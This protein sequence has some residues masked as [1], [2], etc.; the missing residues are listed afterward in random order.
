MLSAAHGAVRLLKWLAGLVVGIVV[1][2]VLL[3]GG[4]LWRLHQGPLDVTPL[5]QRVLPWVEPSLTV[6]RLTL[7]LADGRVLRLGVAG[8]AWAGEDGQPPD[9]IGSATLGFSL[10][11]LL[12]GGIVPEDI[13]A[14][15]VR[16][17][18]A[19]AG[20]GSGSGSTD[21]ADKLARIQHVSVSDVQVWVVDGP[22][23]QGWRVADGAADFHR[24]REGKLAGQATAT[25]AAGTVSAQVAAQ[26]SYSPDAAELRLTL[27]PLSPAAVAAAVPQLAPLQALDATVALRAQASFGAGL[28][29]KAASVHAEAGAGV[30]HL[31]VDG[32][33]TSPARFDSITLDAEGTPAK[34]RVAGLRLVLP[35]PSGAA[36][37]TLVVSGTGERSDGRFRAELAVDLDH[38][39]FADLPALWPEHVGGNAR[40]WLTENLT[41]GTAH[42]AHVAFTLAGTE[43]G[44][45]LAI[46]DASGTLAAEDVTAWWLRP[47]PPIEHGRVNVA[48]QSPD[49]VLVTVETG[50]QGAL[51]ISDGSVRITGLTGRD[52]V[53]FVATDLAGP[54]GN[55]FTLLRN[56]RLR[57]LSKHPVPI[58]A[59][60]GAVSAHLTVQLPLDSKVSVDQVQI[61]AAGKV[62]NTH[63]GGI[64]AGR[65]IDRGQLAFDVTN[66][67]L[68]VEGPAQLDHL[69]GKLAVDMDFR[70][71]PP[72]QVVQHAA[73]SVRL[74][75]RGADAAG[76]AALGLNAG[77]IQ[78]SVD[79]TE[80]RDGSAT[81][82]AGADLH[83][84]GLKTPLGWSKVAGTP[85]RIE[86]T[87]LLS[88]GKLVGLEGVRAEAPGL[89]VEA[90]SEMVGGVPSVVHIERGEI[91]RTSLTGTIALPQREG[92]AYK[93]TLAGPRLDLEGP[94]QSAGSPASS[95]AKPASSG[96]GTPYAVDLR[97]QQVLFGPGRAL[98]P[99]R[100]TAQGTGRRVAAGRLETG[101]PERVQASLVA[102]GPER[103]LWATAADLG[104]LL[105]QSG[106][107]AALN[108]GRL[109]LDGSF[110]DRVASSPFDGTVDLRD[111]SVKGT[112]AAVGKV[113]QGITVYGLVDA[114]SGPGLVFDRLASPFHLDGSV[115]HVSDARAYSASLG[116][117][118]TGSLDFDRSMV[119]LKGTIVPAYFFNALPGRLP[120]L[121]RLFS[122][123]KGSGVFAADFTLRGK[124]GAPH[125]GIN[126]LSVLTPGITRRLFDLFD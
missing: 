122:P 79:Y 32:G 98:G 24:G 63:I 125:V 108:G 67:G 17:H 90:R 50:K 82:H 95:G 1:L 8:A 72:S 48:W 116:L 83:E 28:A 52:Q 29:L 46:T 78:A 18:V 2:A 35:S 109:I 112:P 81:V 14:D 38:A 25:V 54:L 23:G 33:G 118:A 86:A 114:L 123:E 74:T 51:T 30:A 117:T 19:G 70:A 121:G 60:T 22:L 126:P 103:R 40:A 58:T 88:H 55:L 27:S 97:V 12:A 6:S 80:R 104:L 99:V 20:S 92:G 21:L 4:L 85:G 91:G 110:D 34:A 13:V 84:A 3:L 7:A 102:A 120:L 44:S 65:D 45:E 9:A 107:T 101:G 106:V 37:T 59:P 111:F 26:G 64:A 87:A 124:L 57:L 71:G 16:L 39:A 43:D 77:S 113:L 36:P 11:S 5:A 100:L 94:L 76:L 53:A 105:R 115:L 42:D 56:P 96:P 47:V 119:D 89:S 41:A 62:A 93:V 31:P 49:V 10:P 66:D 75:E 61:H 73:A 69:P 68:H 15:R